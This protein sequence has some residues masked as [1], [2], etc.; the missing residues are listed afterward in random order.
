MRGG[1][2]CWVRCQADEK[3][4]IIEPNT[5][6]EK[7]V[8]EMTSKTDPFDFSHYWRPFRDDTTR[9]RD[10]LPLSD[11]MRAFNMDVYETKNG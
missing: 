5:V 4:V 3:T 8:N 11:K 1:W 7:V 10:I 9:V 6:S 2:D